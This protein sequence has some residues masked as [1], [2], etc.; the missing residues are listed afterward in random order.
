MD[1]R[2]PR[3]DGLS[4]STEFDSLKVIEEKLTAALIGGFDV[5]LCGRITTDGRREFYYYAP[6]SERLEAAVEGAMSQF[7]NYEFDCGSKTDPEWRQYLGVL[8]PSDEDR[9][10]IE[11]RKVLEVLYREKRHVKSASGCFTLDLLSL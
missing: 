2:W 1:L 9:Q 8:Y 11:N 7:R 3:E 6:R 10:R 4:A 5:V